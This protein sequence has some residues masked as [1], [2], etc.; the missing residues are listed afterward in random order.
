MKMKCA[1]NDVWL[2]NGNGYMVENGEYQEHLKKSDEAK[3]VT[4][5][6]SQAWS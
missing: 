2:S 3:E 1:Q 4:D 6:F 5:S